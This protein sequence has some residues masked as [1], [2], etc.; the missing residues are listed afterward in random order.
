MT[1]IKF[2]SISNPLMIALFITISLIIFFAIVDPYLSKKR[3]QNHNEY[4]SSK[5]ASLR[6]IKK[7][8]R[9]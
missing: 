8:F 2:G 7:L 9:I 6:E 1:D 4:G 3:L 5:F